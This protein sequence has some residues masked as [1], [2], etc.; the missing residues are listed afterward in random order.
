M[1]SYIVSFF[2]I[3]MIISLAVQKLFNCSP[4]CLF[5]PL[6]V[7]DISAKIILHKIPE[8]LLPMFPSRIFM[9]SQLIFKSFIHFEFILVYG[10]SW[11]SSF[12]FCMYQSSSPNT[13]YCRGC[14][15]SIVCLSLLCQI[16]IDHRNTGL[17]LGPLFCYFDLCI[18]FYA[19]ARLFSL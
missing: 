1:F 11:W 13:T 7:R 15:Y 16:L 3:L 18:C 14:F 8:I 5:F 4:L 12:I 9:V 10:V 19:S 17:F 6:G 2:F